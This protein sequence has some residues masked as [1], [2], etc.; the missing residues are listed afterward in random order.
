MQA[1][2]VVVGDGDDEGEMEW[3]IKHG[4]EIGGMSIPSLRRSSEIAAGKDG[5]LLDG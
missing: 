5:R 1:C 3:A 2:A 4:T